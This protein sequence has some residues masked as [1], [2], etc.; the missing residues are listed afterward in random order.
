MYKDKDKQREAQRERTR[1]YRV[2]QKSIRIV[3]PT[4]ISVTPLPDNYGEPDCQCRHC[5]QNRAN[6]N[7]H[8]INHS[9]YKAQDQLV[10]NEV[11]RVSL[12]GDVD[13][14]GISE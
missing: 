12:P 10:S 3:T 9:H 14:V 11:N 7:K 4:G 6:R 5:Q 13:Y 2:K 1:R 8:I